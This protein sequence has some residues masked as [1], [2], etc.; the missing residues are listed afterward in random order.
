MGAEID[1]FGAVGEI[2]S[3]K[4]VFELISPVSGKVITINETLIEK[5]EL[6]NQNPYE[7][8]WIAEIGLTD[9]ENDKELLIGFEPYF[10]ILKTKVKEIDG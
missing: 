5:P 6:I 1:Q 4:S 2:E 8:G 3:S 7:S 9:F 10:E